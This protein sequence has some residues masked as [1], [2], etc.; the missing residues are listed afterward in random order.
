MLNMN[1]N[2]LGLMAV[3]SFVLAGLIILASLAITRMRSVGSKQQESA[4]AA[5]AVSCVIAERN[6]FGSYNDRDVTEA[7][8]YEFYTQYYH[9]SMLEIDGTN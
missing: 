5:F 4:A 1:I 3:A 8:N 6:E 2:I 9:E 7:E